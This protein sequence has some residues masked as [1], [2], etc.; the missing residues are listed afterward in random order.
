MAEAWARPTAPGASLVPPDRDAGQGAT[1]PSE[2]TT[3]SRRNGGKYPFAGGHIACSSTVGREARGGVRSSSRLSK[4]AG[5]SIQLRDR[6]EAGFRIPRAS[7]WPPASAPRR[8]ARPCPAWRTIACAPFSRPCST[9]WG[10]GTRTSPRRRMRRFA[11]SWSSPARSGRIPCLPGNVHHAAPWAANGG[12]HAS[13]TH[14][15]V[16]AIL[17]RPLSQGV[18]VRKPFRP[19]SWPG[20]EQPLRALS[21]PRRPTWTLGRGPERRGAGPALVRRP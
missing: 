20:D 3:L 10:G 16:S 17:E 6:T 8:P 14:E 18:P 12:H 9:A 1:P 19:S 7:S 15:S 2:L 5:V 4:E 13:A 21:S 11:T